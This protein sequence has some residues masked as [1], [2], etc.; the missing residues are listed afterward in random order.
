MRA[1]PGTFSGK[2]AVF[3]ELRQ[4]P[5]GVVFRLLHVRLIEG[6]DA[7]QRAGD[8]GG[9]LP[10]I[11]FRAEIERRLQ[12]VPDDRVSGGFQLLQLGFDR[13]IRLDMDVGEEA[14]MIVV[15]GHAQGFAGNRQNAFALFAGALGDQLLNPQ[16][17]G[18]DRRG[19]DQR[20]LVAAL[21]RAS[22]HHG[23]KPESGI[24]LRRH[25]C[26]AALHHA[27]GPLEQRLDI[28][29]H[30]GKRNHAEKGER[31]IASADVGRIQKHAAEVVALGVGDQ[32]RAGIG[33]GH[34]VTARVVAALFLDA[35][36]E[37]TV[38]H[39]AARSW[40]PTSKRR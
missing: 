7:E 38:K 29:A 13:R 11:K 9:K 35:G 18:R 10:E 30:D 17:H 14:I 3:I 39:A 1:T 15:F 16:T 12:L 34:E 37:V 19:G 6:V 4:Q 27:L 5:P 31:R 20:K 24:V 33:D 8:G 26:P 25:G 2:R 23:A 28:A 21:V 32:L 22:R 40:C 36:I